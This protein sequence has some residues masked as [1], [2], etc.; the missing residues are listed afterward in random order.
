[1]SDTFEFDY[2]SFVAQM[3]KAKDRPLLFH[4][5]S[6][7]EAEALVAWCKENGFEVPQIIT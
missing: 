3:E 5:R 2:D 4:A 7:E 6:R 1:M